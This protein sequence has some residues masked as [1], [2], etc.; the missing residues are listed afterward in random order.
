MKQRWTK[1]MKEIDKYYK[2]VDKKEMEKQKKNRTV[3]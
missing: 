2:D 3:F 1:L